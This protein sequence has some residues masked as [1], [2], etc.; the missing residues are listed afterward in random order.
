MKFPV[1]MKKD[2]IYFVPLGGCGFFGANMALYGYNDEWI[3]VDCGMGFAD[4]TMPGVDVLL[5]DPAFAASLGDKLKGIVLTHGHEDHIG[6]IESLWPR[7][8]KPMYATKF[9]AGRIKLAISDEPWRDQAKVNLVEDNGTLDIGPFHIR[10][11]AMAHSIPEAYALAITVKGAGTLLHT[12]D[13]KIDPNPVESHVTDE[14]ALRALGDAGVMAVLGDSTNAMVPGHSGSEAD[15]AANLVD[16]FQG[17]KDK[18]IAI[19]CFSTNVARLRSITEAAQKAG[20]QV[21]L[22]GRSLWSIDEVARQ[23]GYL[24]DLPQFLSDEQANMLNVDELVYICTGSQGEPRAALNRISADDHP[25]LHLDEGDVV[26]FSSRAI[27]GNERA[28]DRIK[29]R[30]YAMGVTIV[31][32]RDAKVHV[33]GHGYRD[34]IGQ[35]YQWVRPKY[36]VPVHGEQM[37]MEKHALLAQDNGVSKTLIPT[38]GNIIEISQDN[39]HVVGEVPSGILA[40]EGN[41]IVAIDHEAILTRK[42]IMW[43]GSAVVTVVVDAKGHLIAAPKITALGLLDENNDHDA[44]IIAEA[45]TMI[46]KTVKNAPAEQRAD[47]QNLSELVRIT[48]RKFFTEKFDRKPQTRVHLVRV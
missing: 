28:I 35:L 18:G 29:N 23:T 38:N 21:C 26:I 13:W 15:V 46:S 4:D 25:A 22:V 39:L 7:I 24:K 37:Q 47:D 9:T 31:T 6:A 36:A 44:E 34:E 2:A 12:G 20:R 5:P 27:P 45:A 3:M 41:R 43:N 32:D 42:R 10:F 1:E 16:L 19:S 17:F 33:S 30:L 11:I 48:A 40:I 14:A 8:R